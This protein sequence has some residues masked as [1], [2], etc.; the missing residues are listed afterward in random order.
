MNTIVLIKITV[1]ILMEEIINAFMIAQSAKNYNYHILI[2]K[3]ILHVN[4]GK[5]SYKL[6]G[7]KIFLVMVPQ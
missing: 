4:A 7:T 5:Y 1:S 6:V 3:E 2:V